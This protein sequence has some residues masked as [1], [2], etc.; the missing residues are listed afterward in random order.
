MSAVYAACFAALRP[1]GLMVTVTKNT[2]RKA[3][4]LD[5]AGLT[6]G[7]AQGIGFTYLQHVVALH[8]A[9]RD[10]EMA[11]RASFWQLTQTRK[12]RGRGEPAHLVV[13][14]DVEVFAKGTPLLAHTEPE[15]AHAH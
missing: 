1:G 10:S 7:L 15:V 8:A 6:V 9:V 13:H 4:T 11:S 12:A 3:R 5:L 2:R 14:E